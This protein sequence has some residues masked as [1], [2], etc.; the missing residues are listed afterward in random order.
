MGISY[1]D[2]DLCH[3]FLGEL[4]GRRSD[5]FL[6]GIK[7][8]HVQSSETFGSNLELE[9][10]IGVIGVQESLNEK[11]KYVDIKTLLENTD[12]NPPKPPEQPKLSLL[13]RASELR[14]LPSQFPASATQYR[15]NQYGCSRVRK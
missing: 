4:C 7:Q 14:S 6:F 2:R 9:I 8:L 11:Q 12:K 13:P 15:Q 10:C 5:F 3:R 1:G